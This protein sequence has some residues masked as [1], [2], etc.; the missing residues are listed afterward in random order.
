M[1]RHGVIFFLLVVIF[2]TSKSETL[3]QHGRL[4]VSDLNPHYLQ[5]EDGTPFFWLGDTG[6]DLFLRL[7]REGAIWYID[8]RK[9]QGFNI[10]QAVLISEFEGVKIP[11]YNDLP[12]ID[13]DPEKPLVTS[14]NDI[15]SDEAYDYRDHIDYLVNYAEK[16]GITLNC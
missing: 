16:Q 9:S 1:F 10:I 3:I 6:W 11:N 5:F 4:K 12:F 7:S 2:F 15:N 8:Q 13:G 14:G